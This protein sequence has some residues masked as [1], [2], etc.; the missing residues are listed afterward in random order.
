M[1]CMNSD[2][3]F[4]IVSKK[5]E[6]TSALGERLAAVLEGNEV[7]E[8][9]GDLGAGKT[10]F[11][12][13]LARG[14]GSEDVVQSPSFTISREYSGGEFDIHHYDL[15]RLGNDPGIISAEIAESIADPKVVVVSEWAQSV[16]D[17]LPD[18]RI[19]VT[20][21]HSVAEDERN[22]TVRA[23][24]QYLEALK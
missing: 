13:G 21:T 22:I 3:T 17:V 8:L 18:G 23:A 10:Q 15:Y 16:A 20:I 2:T 1:H 5:P 12:R 11:V 24:E 6:D 19:T 7:I 9:I 14:I 4:E